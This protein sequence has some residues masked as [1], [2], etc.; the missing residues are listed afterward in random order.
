MR[1]HVREIE[2]A[3]DR[4]A[5]LTR[6]LLAFSRRQPV[7]PRVLDLNH[8]VR[9]V[10]QM[11]RRVISD[12]VQMIVRAESRM[13]AVKADPGQMEQVLVNLAI[14]ARDAMP[15]GGVLTIVTSDVSLEPA[16]APNYALPPGRYVELSVQDT[17]HG[18]EEAIRSRIFEP[19]FT[20]KPGKGTGLGLSIVYGIVQQSGGSITVA[21]QPGHGATFKVL[22]PRAKSPRR[23]RPP[24]R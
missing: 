8:L 1:S 3:A 19:F 5:A 9:G 23:P 13:A 21:S 17:G 10:C 24:D 11:L 6:Q 15:D 12:K 20:T 22:L 16:E 2:N 4:G 7:E 18:I 14:N